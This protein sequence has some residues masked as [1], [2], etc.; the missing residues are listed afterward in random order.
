[1][2]RNYVLQVTCD[3][4]L[5]SAIAKYQ[6]ENEIKTMSEAGKKLIEFA[7]RIIENS[8]EKE[9]VSNRELMEEILKITQY[10]LLTTNVVHGQTFDIEN[11]NKNKANASKLR[12]ELQ[13]NAENRVNV[14]LQG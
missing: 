4:K 5:K 13:K 14:F 1:M 12:E 9:G 10:N 3:E 2:A 7:L 11:L 6:N 8:N